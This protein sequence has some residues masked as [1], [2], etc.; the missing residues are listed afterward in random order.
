MGC[1]TYLRFVMK[2]KSF[3]VLAPLAVVGLVLSGCGGSGGG[4]FQNEPRASG[5]AATATVAGSVDTTLNGT[6]ASSDVFLDDVVKVN[7]IGGDPETCRTRFSNLPK[8]GGAQIMDGDIRY[9]P[10]TTEARVSIVS[11][12]TIEFELAGTAGATVNRTTNLITYSNAVFT[13]KQDPSRTIT[14]TAS[15]PIR[16]ENKPEGC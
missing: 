5:R 15:I 16:A 10:G 11:I 6:Y 1:S 7:P 8:T 13:A 14:L 12:N 4:D 3:K 9:I 2:F